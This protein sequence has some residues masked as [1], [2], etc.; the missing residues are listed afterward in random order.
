MFDLIAGLPLHPLIVHA[1]EVVV[2]MAVLAVALAA[3]WPRFRHWAYGLPVVLASGALVLTP[4]A[5]KSG[6]ALLTRVTVTELVTTHVDLGESLL[7]WVGLLFLAAVGLFWLER[8]ERA[9]AKAAAAPGPKVIPTGLAALPRQLVLGLTVAALVTGA[10]T[11]VQ[12]V[13]IGHSGAAAVWTSV[14]S[15]EPT[16]SVEPS[17]STTSEPSPSSS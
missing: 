5:I 10:G 8:Q 1:T 4:L 13:R 3:L 7:P 2:P 17:S 11:L 15:P 6:E 14:V 16:P 12:A 9:N